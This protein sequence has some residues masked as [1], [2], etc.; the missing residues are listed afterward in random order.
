MADELSRMIRGEA[1]DTPLPPRPIGRMASTFDGVSTS[2]NRV[3]LGRALLR[4]RE[5]KR[6]QVLKL[7]VSQSGM[8]EAYL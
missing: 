8:R 1:D 7:A 6:N 5:R 3:V 4:Q 2:T